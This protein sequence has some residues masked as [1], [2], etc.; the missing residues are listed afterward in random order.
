M[1]IFNRARSRPEKFSQWVSDQLRK[2]LPAGY[3]VERDFSPPYKPW[4]QRLCLVPDGDLFAAM[5]SG[6]AAIATGTIERFTPAGIRLESGEEIRADIIVTATGLNMQMLGGV[7][8]SVDGEPVRAED[9][10]IYK[11]MM[12]SDVPN[13]F[14][15]FG[16][17][18]ASWT[19]RSDLTARSVCRLLNHMDR[20]RAGRCVARAQADVEPRPIMDLTSGYVKRAEA[21]LPKQGDREPWRVPQNYVRDLIGMTFGR[22]DAALE[23]T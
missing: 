16:Y 19:L 6:K 20:A 4:D 21:M 9:R 5:R 13:L 10:L 23:I 7:E 12:L 8:I 14:I 18:N 22:I 2:E 15:A 1:L 11:G 3:P 17:T